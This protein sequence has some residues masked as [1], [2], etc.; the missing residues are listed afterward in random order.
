MKKYWK[1]FAEWG[2]GSKHS[3]FWRARLN[4]TALYIGI[5]AA[6][7]I[8]FSFT[9]YYSLVKNIRDNV[10]GNFSN[11][12]VQELV[13][14]KTTDQLQMTIVFVDLAVL[15]ISSV[16][17]YVL[18]GRTLKPIQETM[19]K[20]KQFTADASHEL[21]TPLTV[22]RTNLEVALREKEW[23]KEKGRSFITNAIDEI[24]LMTKL[25]EDLL[26]LSKLEGR[27]KN[28]SFGKINITEIAERVV[29]KMRHMATERNIKL[30]MEGSHAVFL[31]G[32]SGAL[33]R[34]VTNIVSNALA[35]TKSR[36]SIHVTVYE[37]HAKAIVTIQDTGIGIAKEDL[38]HVFE[39]L[40]RADKARSETRGAGLGLAIAEEITR[41]HHG[42]IRIESELGKGTLVII[43][44]PVPS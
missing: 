9:L 36:G 2:T 17:S 18:A 41:N 22:A 4:L 26:T 27:E 28:L 29:K 37:R 13:M 19:E 39:R 30:S 11:D 35:F 40:Y 42:T 21:R 1:P 7:V 23:D 10:E 6:I 24:T 3:L 43:T 5:I 16:L 15:G 14:G 33:E 20:Q 12:Q 44:F 8:I 34:L 32:E 25:T 31:Y 38:P